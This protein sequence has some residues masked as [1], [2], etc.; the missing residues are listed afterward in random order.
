MG[1]MLQPT[2]TPRSARWLDFGRQVCR[3]LVHLIYPPSCHLCG[4]ALE[5]DTDLFCEVCAK[6]LLEDRHSTCP[7]CGATVGAFVDATEGC[8]RCHDTT[9]HFQQVLRLGPYQGRLREA[10]LRMKHSSGEELAHALGSLWANYAFYWFKE[11]SA[12]YVI[13][14]P[15]HW[16]RRF[17]RG[18]NQ[19][20]T[21]ARVLAKKLNLP[22]R[23]RWLWR[24][25]HTPSQGRQS[26]TAR[27]E[28][29]RG[30]FKAATRPDLRS[31]TVL[32]VDD[33]LTTGS[34][35][36]EAAHALRQVGTARIV[37][38]VLARSET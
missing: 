27:R 10:V 31:K 36:S 16:L 4:Q 30:A 20:E 22:C 28:N 9:F 12:D 38:A 35:C 24:T 8:L 29:V 34:T 25:K 17:K 13:P 26:A 6:E 32:L 5:S 3:G 14:V 18:Y 15:L 1:I 23:P 2:A 33:V 7:R 19:A 37:V 21:L 11:V